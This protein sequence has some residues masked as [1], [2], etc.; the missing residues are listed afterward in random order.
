MDVLTILMMIFHNLVDSM[1]GCPLIRLMT[2]TKLTSPLRILTGNF[3]L[4]HLMITSMTSFIR[5]LLTRDY[6]REE[7]SMNSSKDL[8]LLLLI[9][10]MTLMTGTSPLI[11]FIL[12]SS[13]HTGPHSFHSLIANQ[14][15]TTWVIPKSL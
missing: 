11:I 7:T 14:T 6:S 1:K 12:S 2:G 3:P 4:T 9:I 8:L 5:D 13:G 15:S 10:I